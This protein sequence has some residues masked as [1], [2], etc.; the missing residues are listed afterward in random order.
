M[1]EQ[2][3]RDW[4]QTPLPNSEASRFVPVTPQRFLYAVQWINP[5][6]EK[7]IRDVVFRSTDQLPIPVLLAVTRHGK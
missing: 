6:P 1:L 5:A 3:L 2:N 4:W 7:P